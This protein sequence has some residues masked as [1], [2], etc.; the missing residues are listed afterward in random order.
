M[1]HPVMNGTARCTH[2]CRRG[3]GFDSWCFLYRVPKWSCNR[4]CALLFQKFSLLTKIAENRDIS[5][6]NWSWELEQ[7]QGAPYRVHHTGCTRCTHP[8]ALLREQPIWRLTSSLTRKYGMR[9]LRERPWG[10]PPGAR[11]AQRTFSTTTTPTRTSIFIV[12]LLFDIIM[13]FL[14]SSYSKSLPNFTYFRNTSSA[15]LHYLIAGSFW[16]PVLGYPTSRV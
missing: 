14:N 7:L 13:E 10:E 1:G 12:T 2:C 5:Q 15:T 4:G 8:V 11:H 3:L 9:E 6:V 16:D